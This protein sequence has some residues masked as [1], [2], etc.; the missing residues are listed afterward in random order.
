MSLIVPVD[1]NLDWK[2]NS[3]KRC[4]VCGDSLSNHNGSKK[5]PH[6][7]RITRKRCQT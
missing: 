7:P 2:V 6:H 1:A 3:P 5:E 4:E